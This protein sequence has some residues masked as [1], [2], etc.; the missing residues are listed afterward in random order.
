VKKRFWVNGYKLLQLDTLDN[1][2]INPNTVR[3]VIDISKQEIATHDIIIVADN[4]H[5]LMTDKL[6]DT[7]RSLAQRQR[8]AVY[9]DCQASQRP[10][11]AEKYRDFTFICLNEKEAVELDSQ[12]SDRKRLD[13]LKKKLGET[14]I[15]VK[16]GGRGSLALVNE[17]LIRTPAAKVKA[18]DTCG[19]G[20]AFLSAFSLG[21]P[22]LADE[23][24]LVANI[25]AGL[26]VTKPGINPPAK[27]ELLNYIAGLKD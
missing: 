12:F 4:Q 17:R 27:R 11:N 2:D 18:V 25:W 1:R 21:N 15:C 3:A 16:L 24:L 20:D 14:N 13:N 6:I 23:S 10:S 9:V 26:S 5:G 7:I 22:T 8:K 19:A